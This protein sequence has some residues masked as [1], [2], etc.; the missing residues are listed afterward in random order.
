MISNGL[1]GYLSERPTRYRLAL[2]GVAA[3]FRRNMLEAQRS[4]HFSGAD[5]LLIPVGHVTKTMRN[6]DLFL[7]IL[8]V[9]RL[10]IN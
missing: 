7:E 10:Q 8:K 5:F 3:V 2:G 1:N 9:K 4:T 6:K